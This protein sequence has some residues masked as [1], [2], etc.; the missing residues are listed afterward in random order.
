MRTEC[1]QMFFS[2][3]RLRGLSKKSTAPILTARSTSAWPAA[4]AISTTGVSS[5]ASTNERP[6]ASSAAT[7]LACGVGGAGGRAG[8]G[9]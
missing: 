6:M 2:F 7:T 8:Q 1:C 3:S 4:A 5:N 9:W